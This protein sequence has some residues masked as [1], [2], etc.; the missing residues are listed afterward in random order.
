MEKTVDDIKAIATEYK[1][2]PEHVM[3]ECLLEQDHWASDYNGVDIV[4]QVEEPQPNIQLFGLKEPHHNV[5]IYFDNI[6]DLLFEY[7]LFGKKVIDIVSEL[8]SDSLLH[9]KSRRR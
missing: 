2:K 7:T 1:N 3:F 8:Y 5:I 6:H 9:K 4:I